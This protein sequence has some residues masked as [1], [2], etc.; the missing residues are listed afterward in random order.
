MLCLIKLNGWPLKIALYSLAPYNF[1]LPFSKNKT[2]NF[3]NSTPWVEKLCIWRTNLAENLINCFSSLDWP[4][5]SGQVQSW[6]LNKD[7][8][9]HVLETTI[10]NELPHHLSLL[11]QQYKNSYLHDAQKSIHEK[12]HNKCRFVTI[13]GK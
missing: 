6:N 8:I 12:T 5:L 10:N 9:F 1:K 13:R 7:P 4:Q 3:Y 11:S 2:W